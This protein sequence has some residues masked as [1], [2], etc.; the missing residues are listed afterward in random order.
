MCVPSNV[1]HTF[2]CSNIRPGDIYIDSA[3]P[4]SMQYVHLYPYVDKASTN[5]AFINIKTEWGIKA[6]FCRIFWLDVGDNQRGVSS[7]WN[8]LSVEVHWWIL[9]YNCVRIRI[10]CNL[11]DLKYKRSYNGHWHNKHANCVFFCCFFQSGL[12]LP[13]SMHGACKHIFSFI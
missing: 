7:G 4:A 2:T 11:T 10:S 12:H 6:G 8:H 5:F 9:L 3:K 13:V 1:Q